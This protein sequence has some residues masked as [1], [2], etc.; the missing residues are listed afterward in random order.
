[1]FKGT[2]TALVTPFHEDY[3][4]D[5]EGL[6]KNISFQLEQEVEGLLVLGT[7]GETPTLKVDERK[8]V[9]QTC[10][11]LAKGKAAILVGT[12]TYDTEESIQRTLEA[13]KMGA[14]M[15]LVVTPYYNCPTQEGIVAHFSAIDWHVEIP[16]CVYNI[17][18][19]TGRQITAETMCRLIELDNVVA[20]KEASGDFSLAQEI[21]YRVLEQDDEI[22]IFSG[23]D[24]WTLPLMSLGACGVISVAS[25]LFPERVSALVQACLR[26]D[27][28]LGLQI[29]HSLHTLFQ[30]LFVESNPIPLKYAMSCAGLPAGP[31][32]LPL[33]GLNEE[34]KKRVKKIVSDR[35]AV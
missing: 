4:L 21:L 27:F 9:I 32:R 20:I 18:K 7:T 2:I 10:V 25:N 14:D 28:S 17:G 8:Q 29:Q 16:L 11:D 19:R 23:D 5:L 13:Q 15:A 35:V 31:C 3:S 1:M 6:K 34:N 33:T 30:D 24:A 12:G 26:K 22:A